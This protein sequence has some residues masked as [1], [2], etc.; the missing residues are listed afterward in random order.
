MENRYNYEIVI[1][2]IEKFIGA[3]LSSF[4]TFIHLIL[5]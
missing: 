1:I 4:H 2:K 5:K 3:V